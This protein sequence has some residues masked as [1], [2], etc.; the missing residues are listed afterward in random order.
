M[1]ITK[2]ELIKMVYSEKE[3]QNVDNRIPPILWAMLDTSEYVMDYN[4][5]SAGRLT[6]LYAK[7]WQKH[8][9]DI[10]SYLMKKKGIERNGSI[11]YK[12]IIKYTDEVYILQEKII[13]EIHDKVRQSK[14]KSIFTTEK[15]ILIDDDSLSYSLSNNSYLKELTVHS[16]LDNNGYGYSYY[17]LSI[18]QLANLLDYIN[19]L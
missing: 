15:A 1:I 13:D 12:R 11:L 16:L 18:H 4:E 3:L 17:I 8:N 7:L 2:E 5:N 6:N 19:K 14:K 10:V 9:G